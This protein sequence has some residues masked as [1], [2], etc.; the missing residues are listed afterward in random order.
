MLLEPSIAESTGKR[1]VLDP[2]TSAYEGVEEL[3]LAACGRR[4]H[5]QVRKTLGAS[6]AFTTRCRP[7]RPVAWPAVCVGCSPK[8]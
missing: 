3:E 1:H 8:S 5:S 7:L 6:P 2:Y 4:L